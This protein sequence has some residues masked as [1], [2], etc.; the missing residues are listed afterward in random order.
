LILLVNSE[1]DRLNLAKL[2]YRGI[3]DPAYFTQIQ[4]VLSS[5]SNRNELIT[6][7]NMFNGGTDGTTTHIAM[8]VADYNAL[9]NSVASRF[10]LGAKMTSLVDI[11]ANA[12]YYFTTD[13][14]E[15]LIRL[16][17]SETNRLQLAKSSYSHITDPANFK[18]LYD[19]LGMQSSRNELDAYVKN[20]DGNTDTNTPYRAPMADADYNSLYNSIRNT[21]GFGAKFSALTDVFANT[22][23]YFTVAQA[24]NLIRLVSSE[25]NRLQLAKQSYSHITD[26][27][28]FSDLYDMFGSQSSVN[29]L[30]AYVNSL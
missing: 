19:V 11:F 7:V 21:W 20:Y 18:Q 15:R 16:V 12:S 2:S 27:A 22:N 30:K 26:P 13:Q 10:G 4:D 3:T 28:N 17:S 24:E 25:T 1:A 29:E 5:Q 9:Y 8:S 14:A 23:N 6:Y